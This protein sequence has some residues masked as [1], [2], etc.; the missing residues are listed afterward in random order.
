MLQEFQEAR[1]EKSTGGNVW[2]LQ[3]HRHKTCVQGSAHLI[4]TP[5]LMEE[6]PGIP[7]IKQIFPQERREKAMAARV[8]IQGGKE[9]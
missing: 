8:E 3:V 6:V 4:L 7:T 2:V 9:V 5:H 1:L